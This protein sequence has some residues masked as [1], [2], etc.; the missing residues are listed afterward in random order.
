RR[1]HALEE[2]VR[3]I[4]H[5]PGQLPGEAVVEDDPVNP[6]LVLL[7]TLRLDVLETGVGRHGQ[8]APAADLRSG[9]GRELLPEERL[10]PGLAVGDAELDLAPFTQEIYEP[11]RHGRVRVDEIPVRAPVHAAPLGAEAGLEE[12]PRVEE[13]ELLGE[14]ERD[15]T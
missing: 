5:E 13:T 6:D 4:P 10:V 7:E 8:P 2:Q 9:E 14:V 3:R 11:I 15:R 12:E 1:G